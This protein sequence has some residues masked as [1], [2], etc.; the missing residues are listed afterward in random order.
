ML[1]RSSSNDEVEIC[2]EHGIFF[3]Y[4]EAVNK[5]IQLNKKVLTKDRLLNGDIKVYDNS[6]DYYDDDYDYDDEKLQKHL[7]TNVDEAAEIIACAPCPYTHDT[8]TV[9]EFD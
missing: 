9:I 7:V 4:Q 5:A 1:T 6:Y 2:K 8:Y 3:D